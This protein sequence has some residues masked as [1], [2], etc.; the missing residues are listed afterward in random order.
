MLIN[1]LLAYCAG[2]ADQKRIAPNVF[3]SREYALR[4]AYIFTCSNGVGKELESV[5]PVLSSVEQQCSIKQAK[6]HRDQ[7]LMEAKQYR[8]LAEQ[9]K[10]EKREI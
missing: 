4:H 6:D 5:L 7:A 9:V 1:L 8:N 10:R 2:L 3:K